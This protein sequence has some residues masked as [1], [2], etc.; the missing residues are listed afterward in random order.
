MSQWTESSTPA[1]VTATNK[2]K[3]TTIPE[4]STDMTEII[5]NLPAEEY[6]ANPA[7]GS[8]S[9]RYLSDP[10]ISLQEVKH[11]L[12]HDEHK[13]E[14]DVGTLAHALIL[15]GSMDHLIVEVDAN[16]YRTKAARE[17]RDAAYAAN[18]IPVNNAEWATMMEPI[19]GMQAAVYHHDIARDLLTDHAPEVSLF[20]EQSGVP[21][22]ARIDALHEGRK[23]AVDLKTV[24][25]ARPN[26]FKRQISDLAYYVQ[27]S[28]YLNGLETVTGDK[29]DW[30]FVAVEKSEPHVVSVHRMSPDALT[31]GSIRIG[32]A[33]DRYKAAQERGWTGYEAIFTQELTP[34]E[35]M[36]NES[37]LDDEIFIGGAA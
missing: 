13:K 10:E 32:H 25:S 3:Q 11:L 12:E 2:P 5:H 29:Y 16:D 23:L 35:S 17:A 28:H 26:D 7:F 21:M 34:W 6:F 18:K 9:I 14:Y 15:E 20:W 27:A 1:F 37:L 30:L 8:T 31:E 33:I 4:K 24:R 22:K 36:K 19:H